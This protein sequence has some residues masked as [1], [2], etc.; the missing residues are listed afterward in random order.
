MSK[1]WFAVLFIVPL[2]LGACSDD[3]PTESELLSAAEVEASV[4][5]IGA[6]LDEMVATYEAGDP[7]QAGELAAEAYLENYEDLEH[8]IEEADEALNEEIES[9]LGTQMRERISDGAE[10]SEL[11]AM[12][13]AAKALLDR[14]VTAVRDAA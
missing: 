11:S 5:T 12:V 9:L 14:A 6:L 7:E 2:L 13:D 8:T 1:R 10:A 4:G 3:E